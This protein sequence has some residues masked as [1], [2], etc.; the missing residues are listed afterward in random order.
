MVTH[1]TPDDEAYEHGVHDGQQADLLDQAVQSVTKGI[2]LPGQRRHDE[3]YNKGYDYGVAHR[4]QPRHD[5]LS[6]ANTPEVNTSPSESGCAQVI[7]V[8]MGVGIIIAIAIWLLA[9]VVLPVVLLNS[10]AILAICAL[11]VPDRKAVFA[12]L[13]FV[14]A[15]YML[16]DISN[17]WFSANFVTRVVHSPSWLTA[18]VYINAAATGLCAWVLLEPVRRRVVSNGRV[19]ATFAVAA[20]ILIPMVVLPLIYHLRAPFVVTAPEGSA[21]APVPQSTN[22]A[23]LQPSSETSQRQVSASGA[24]K[25]AWFEVWL[26]PGFTVIPS[27]KSSTSTE[28]YDSAFFRAPDGQ[29]EFYIYSPQW[30][31]EPTD[32]L[33]NEKTEKH[34]G[35]ETSTSKANIVTWFT[36]RAA[37]GSYT[38]TYQDTRS[39]DGSIRWIVGVKYTNQSAYE[40][41]KADYRRFKQSV[42]QFAD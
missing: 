23:L 11:A 16:L 20:V 27:L 39:R 1:K 8:L 4:P 42:R 31:G 33:I 30:S 40:A 28:G 25:G 15:G 37:D 32:I 6:T 9:N 35:S 22:A 41:Y 26:P 12:S 7:A 34:A 13:A 36:I 5:D 18:F 38:R 19:A 29:V 2:S 24:F 17:A 21:A 10:A 14:G 3:I